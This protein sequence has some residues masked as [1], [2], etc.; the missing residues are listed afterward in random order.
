MASLIAE[1]PGPLAGASPEALFTPPEYTMKD[2]YDAIPAHCFQRNTLLSLGYII[3]DFLY[4]GS[5]AA[6]ATQ[7]PKLPNSYLQTTAWITYTFAQGLIFTGLWELAHECGHGALSKSKRFNYTAGLIIHSFL[8]VPFHSWRFTHSHH[9]KSTNNL[10]RDIA[11]VPTK[12]EAY[13]AE[14]ASNNQIL[15]YIED[16]PIIAFLHLFFHQLIAF[17]IYLTLNNFALERMAKENW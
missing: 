14:H 11:F 8:L 13:I 7:I 1:K 17:P 2:I 3:R 6:I 16:M 5:L 15:E 4:A 9:H 12:K 10:D